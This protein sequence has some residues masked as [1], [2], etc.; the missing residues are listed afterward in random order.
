MNNGGTWTWSSLWKRLLGRGEPTEEPV[1]PTERSPIQQRSPAAHGPTRATTLPRAVETSDRRMADLQLH[2]FLPEAA[3]HLAPSQIDELVQAMVSCTWNGAYSKV[4]GVRSKLGD[5]LASNASAQS[6]GTDVIFKISVP[7]DQGIEAE[8]EIQ[9]VWDKMQEFIQRPISSMDRSPIQGVHL[10]V[11]QYCDGNYG[12]DAKMRS[13]VKYRVVSGDE[14]KRRAKT[15]RPFDFSE[16]SEY[17]S[18]LV[19]FDAPVSSFKHLR[20]YGA[21]YC[22][23]CPG[24]LVTFVCDC[25]GR[26]SG[27]NRQPCPTCGKPIHISAESLDPNDEKC[28]ELWLRAG[29]TDRPK[30]EPVPAM[31]VH[32]VKQVVATP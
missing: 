7:A 1:V 31:A 21:V 25:V 32:G 11:M 23:R 17:G 3:K 12:A 26:A 29:M 6:D 10:F 20:L 8:Q 14:A 19:I 27:T 28:S 9:S 13:N 15:M 2:F 30:T 18:A 24:G 5:D 16:G 4:E 22:G